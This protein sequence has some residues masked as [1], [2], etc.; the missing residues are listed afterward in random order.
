MTWGGRA[1]FCNV[2]GRSTNLDFMTFA[3]R[4]VLGFSGLLFSAS[5][6]SS[7]ASASFHSVIRDP[8]FHVESSS[9]GSEEEV[10]H[11]SD[12]ETESGDTPIP[13]A[14]FSALQRASAKWGGAKV[15]DSS[16][17]E[18]TFDFSYT[19]ESY[20]AASTSGSKSEEEKGVSNTTEMFESETLSPPEPI[21]WTMDDP[22]SLA[23]NG[24]R[25][26]ES[27]EDIMASVLRNAPKTTT[28]NGRRVLGRS[29]REN[30]GRRSLRVKNVN[31]NRASQEQSSTEPSPNPRPVPDRKP[32]TN[33][34]LGVH[35]DISYSRAPSEDEIQ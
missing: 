28:R 12:F 14:L 31:A 16:E 23:L 8:V 24:N 29:M 17:G 20:P 5:L 26:R 2:L 25:R 21:M 1:S 9:E 3:W 6:C 22:D 34:N 18:F 33:Y 30:G 19:P 4:F 13:P 7:S 15:A 27:I 35:S 11:L 10:L 32:F